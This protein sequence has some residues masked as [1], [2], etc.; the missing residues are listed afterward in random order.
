MQNSDRPV[1]EAYG[2]IDSI[3][4]N[5]AQDL[6][7][8]QQQDLQGLRD[9]LQQNQGYY[10]QNPDAMQNLINSIIAI[11][12]PLI[13]NYGVNAILNRGNQGGQGGYPAQGGYPGGMPGLGGQGGL[14]A[15]GGGQGGYPGF[16]GS[17]GLGDLIGRALPGLI[18]GAG[19]LGGLFAG[20]EPQSPQQPASGFPR[21]PP[22][23]PQQPNN[24]SGGEVV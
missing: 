10:Q 11:A 5:H 14:P 23:F 20:Q 9:Q 19:G 8:N 22:Q 7:P 17:G 21:Q 13:L 3:L 24:N 4:G 16:S 1:G 6:Q 15:Q 12:G 18:G 2:L